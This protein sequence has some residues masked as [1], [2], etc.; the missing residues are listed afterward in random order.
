[1]TEEPRIAGQHAQSYIAACSRLPFS[2][3][4]EIQ[5][6]KDLSQQAAQKK[7]QDRLPLL[8]QRTQLGSP[9]AMCCWRCLENFIV[10]L[11]ASPNLLANTLVPTMENIEQSV[12]HLLMIESKDFST[13]ST[14]LHPDGR[15]PT[16]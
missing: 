10:Q 6:Q 5:S 15:R 2:Q 3:A 12:Q 1:V 14:F 4:T 11:D 7:T 8:D 13:E 16:R 9:L